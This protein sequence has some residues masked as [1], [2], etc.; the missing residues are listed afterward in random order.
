MFVGDLREE[1]RKLFL[2]NANDFS[3]TSQKVSLHVH[4]RL[5]GSTYCNCLTRG[6]A[7]LVCSADDF[8][9]IAFSQQHF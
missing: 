3:I 4:R 8:G 5:P 7:G 9:E 6:V 2:G 1:E